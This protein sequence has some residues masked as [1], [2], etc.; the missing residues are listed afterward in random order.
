MGRTGVQ[1]D[2][3]GDRRREEESLLEGD[4]R[5]RVQRGR[6]QVTQIDPAQPDRPLGRVREPH[7]QLGDRRLPGS[8]RTDEGHGLVG[9]DL[10]RH[11]VE[12][13]GFSVRTRDGSHRDAERTVRETERL[14][15]RQH[16]GRLGE[17]RL[18]TFP[19]DDCVWDV[20]QHEPDQPHRER[21][22][23]EQAHELHHGPRA[24][25]T[26]R[27]PPRSDRDQQDDADV[28]EGLE[29]GLEARPESPEP[30][31]RIAE[32]AR[33]R[34]KALDLGAFPAQRLDHEGSVEALVRHRRDLSDE[35]LCTQGGWLGPPAVDPVQHG[36]GR[37]D[38]EPDQ[39]EPD[40][41]QQQGH[42]RERDEQE[43]RRRVREGVDH[44][45]G[46]LDIGLRVRDQLPGRVRPVVGERELPVPIDDV[47]AQVSLDS[48][49]RHA[50]E[51]PTQH[52]AARLDQPDRDHGG[53]A[54]QEHPQPQL[55]T[56]GR[57]DHIVGQ[58]S[59]HDR[60]GDRRRR[61]DRRAGHRD[62]ERH[63]VA[64]DVGPDDGQ[65]PA[66]HRPVLVLSLRHATP[67]A[68]SDP[69]RSR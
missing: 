1:R 38:R 58:P 61:V 66:E 42:D 69:A 46:R 18:D 24:D 64:D 40:V 14:G 3:L 59:E 26:V 32:L 33:L 30:D 49:V 54:G 11:A 7:E 29:R 22:E 36:E 47:P 57:Q 52:D 31:P 10:E 6:R 44:V 16:R 2:V 21:E 65:T 39:R 19:A 8:R 12:D 43:H 25:R 4:R 68:G 13:P 35:L 41:G 63:R 45:G 9:S 17:H 28:R 51:V 20:G 53:H 50:G 37:E 67:A 34:R 48:G 15:G 5:G 62:R 27:D 23:Q 55:V 60:A 56:E